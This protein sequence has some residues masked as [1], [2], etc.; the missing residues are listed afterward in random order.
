[1]RLLAPLPD[2]GI[3][4]LTPGHFLIGQPLEALPDSSFTH[5]HSLSCTTQ[6]MAALSSFSLALLEWWSTEYACISCQLFQK[7]A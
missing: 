5:A 6:T 7:V 1:M 4:A 2:D 3:E